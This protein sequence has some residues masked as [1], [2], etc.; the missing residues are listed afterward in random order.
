MCTQEART[1]LGTVSLCC[2][3]RNIL[4]GPVLTLLLGATTS[5]EWFQVSVCRLVPLVQHTSV[6][7][8]TFCLMLSL[9]LKDTAAPRM[10]PYCSHE[11]TQCF[12]PGNCLSACAR[13]CASA[14]G[15]VRICAWCSEQG[16]VCCIWASR[17]AGSSRG[18]RAGPWLYSRR[19]GNLETVVM[20]KVRKR[21]TTWPPLPPRT[22]Q[23]AG[24]PHS[25]AQGTG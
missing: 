4:T 19:A 5:K 20:M 18:G 8:R 22:P 14:P 9:C 3:C 1:G 6:H 13:A 12:L 24:P 23:P 21:G 11:A 15:H 2:C 10:G 16:C 7:I 25:P 17:S